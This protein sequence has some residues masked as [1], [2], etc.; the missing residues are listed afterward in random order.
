LMEECHVGGDSALPPL[1]RKTL[2]Q[3]TYAKV[4]ELIAH[5]RSCTRP[6]EPMEH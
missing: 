3:K 5:A 1:T 2:A 4:V 6:Q